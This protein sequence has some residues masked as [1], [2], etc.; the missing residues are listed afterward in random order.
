MQRLALRSTQVLIDLAVLAAA[1]A[2]AFLAR[3]DGALPHPAFKQFMLLL[4]YVVAFQYGMLVLFGVTNFAWRYVSLREVWR[5]GLALGAAG[6]VLLTG[7][8]LS[9]VV[10]PAFGYAKHAAIPIGVDIIDFTLA[11]LGVAG[12]RG[13]R[14]ILAERTTRSGLA[15]HRS[16]ARRT[17]LIGAGQAGAMVARE[18]ASRPDL[19]ITP[20]GFLDDDNTKL[21][22][23]IHGIKVIGRIDELPGLATKLGAQQ[24]LISMA[25]VPGETVRRILKLCEGVGL[26]VKIIPGIFEILDG[27][28]NLSRIR[29]VS[30]EDL[31]GRPPVQLDVPALEAFIKGKR[32]LVTGAGGSIGSELCRQIAAFEP[33]SLSLVERAEFH[34]FTIHSELVKRFPD[35]DLRPRICDVCDSKRLDGVFAEDRPEVVFHAAAHKHVPMMEWN[36]GE[37]IKNNVFGTRKV[38]D[39]AHKHG[40]GA[41]VLISTD[42]AVNPTSIMG[43]TKRVAEMYVQ[44]LSRQSKTKFLAVR[45]GNVLGSAGS[46]IPIFQK[47]IEAGGPVTV[48]HPEMKRYFMTIP[49]ACQLVMQAGAMGDGGEIFVLDMGTP[50][51]IADLARDL[52]RLSGFEPEVDIRI[53]YSGIRPGEK[54]FEE[55]GFDAEKMDKTGHDKIFVGR[56]AP[57]EMTKVE[58]NLSFLAGFTACQ[59]AAEVREALQKVVPEMHPDATCPPPAVVQEPSRPALPSEPVLAS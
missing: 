36:P 46:V 24:G 14:R 47:Q 59:S 23:E 30:I 4:P 22:L 33:A 43:T 2:L 8:L 52:I 28:V 25:S 51:K 49:E 15:S 29:P 1:F 18:I 31:L 21:G 50:M 5:I 44:S 39:A 32:V 34:L 3:F 16:A 48:T 9:P 7:R 17:L 57:C 56:L 53:E 26:P 13:F 6:A 38:A 37:A 20:V 11:F 40:A 35:L 12:V 10:A 41:F 19:G 58:A 54:L 27:R 42:K 55:L 45:F